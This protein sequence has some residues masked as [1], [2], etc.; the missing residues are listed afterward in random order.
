M[1]NKIIS[2]SLKTWRTEVFR[3]FKV[4]IFTSFLVVFLSFYTFYRYSYY[5]LYIF[6]KI[7]AESAF[8]L[9]G[10][11]LLLGPSSRLFSFSAPYLVYRKQMGILAFFLALIHG[12]V[13]LFF[14]PSKFPLSTFINPLSWPFVF[15]LTA[16]LILTFI[17]LIS[18]N[19]AMKLIGPSRWW[20]FQYQGVRLAFFF[21]FLHA[22]F[23]K[24]KEWLSWYQSDFV[25][26]DV[27]NSNLPE[28]GLLVWWFMLFVILIR[29]TKYISPKLGKIAFYITSIMIPIIYIVTFCWKLSFK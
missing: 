11:V 28:I 1:K 4:L 5:N 6:N 13:S 14:L 23:R 7:L 2:S 10:I 21:I 9:L 8:I 22:L 3:Y 15:G 19:K 18:N 12:F 25:E 20:R 26:G 17:F 16:T 27:L 29:I 24:G